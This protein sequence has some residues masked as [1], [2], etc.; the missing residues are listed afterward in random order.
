ML[1]E[2]CA[3]RV[4]S[5]QFGSSIY[6]T[7]IL[8]TL[9][10]V[11][12]SMGYLAGGR[13]SLR[14]TSLRPLIISLACVTVYVEI[15]HVLFSGRILDECFTLQ[16]R[17]HTFVVAETLPPGLATLALYVLPMMVLA[18]ISPYL[19][20]L[21][22]H[23]GKGETNGVGVAS[24]KLMATST[25]GSI[26]G[27][28]ATS[29][30]LIPLLG[31]RHTLFFFIALNIITILGG[32]WFSQAPS[33][34]RAYMGLGAVILVI[35][36]FGIKDKVNPW[37]L[38]GTFNSENSKTLADIESSYGT[39]RV[40]D[41]TENDGSLR[42]WYVPSRILIHSSLYVNDPLRGQDFLTYVPDALNTRGG[43]R[44]LILGVAGGSLVRILAELSPDNSVT[45]VE[46]DPTA[47][48]VARRYFGV[49]ER[50]NIRLVSADARA[51]LQTSTETFD[52]ITIDVAAGE[53]IPAHC[54][55]TEFYSLVYNHLSQ[56]GE[57]TI[58]T[59][60]PVNHLTSEV[61][62]Q[63][64]LPRNHILSAILHAGFSSVF[65]T[66]PP[67]NGFLTAFKSPVTYEQLRRRR[68]SGFD[69]QDLRPDLRA[70]IGI[71]LLR[72]LPV[73]PAVISTRPF[74][75]DWVPEPFVQRKSCRTRLWE[76]F[77]EATD[78]PRWVQRWIARG[79]S[80]V[81]VAFARRA[82]AERKSAS[83][84]SAEE[85]ARQLD[86]ALTREQD[87][88]DSLAKYFHGLS[89]EET[90]AVQE[91]TPRTAAILV[92][93]SNAIEAVESNNGAAAVA[94]L[95]EVINRIERR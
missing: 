83:G 48:D 4:L 15:T 11:A 70:A 30:L 50:A 46:L 76:A 2:M 44:F 58:N 7:G 6:V 43:M 39:I 12:L 26:F 20:R 92:P 37:T 66:D 62:P 54:I 16:E 77:D 38:F 8:L 45:A 87:L 24:G 74:V 67:Q 17:I 55:T 36:P 51:F 91:L 90:V 33:V 52:Y 80:E 82:K 56:D 69:N 64:D 27:T 59:T 71:A 61:S 21:M 86:A 93:Y 1:L 68:R 35:A 18:Q 49:P 88:H 40:I 25:V 41:Q 73:D 31:I 79:G 28:L 13:L 29:F 53:R 22:M 42:R 5:T 81:A 63:I 78:D 65:E 32:L 34:E 47:L 60:M 95:T 72:T 75:D 85:F 14:Y 3:F 84:A 9:V 19:V 89:P 57:V 94:A 10:M 23:V